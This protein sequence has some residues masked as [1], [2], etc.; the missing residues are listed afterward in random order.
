[1]RGESA[2]CVS[3]RVVTCSTAAAAQQLPA[4]VVVLHSM[5]RHDQRD[6]LEGCTLTRSARQRVLLPHD[7]VARQSDERS[8]LE[9]VSS[10]APGVQLAIISGQTHP[11]STAPLESTRIGPTR[12]IGTQNTDSALV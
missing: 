5:M 12:S 11:C 10:C 8:T 7:D 2:A 1:M 3:T 4:Q 6:H 9:R